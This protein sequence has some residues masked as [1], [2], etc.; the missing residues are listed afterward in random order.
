MT[1]GRESAKYIFSQEQRE[2]VTVSDITR[3]KERWSSSLEGS[4]GPVKNSG[5]RER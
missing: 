2:A 3:L 5:N 1:R 4:S